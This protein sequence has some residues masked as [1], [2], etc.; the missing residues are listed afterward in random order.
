MN[1]WLLAPAALQAVVMLGDELHFHRRRGLP[2]WER[3]GHPLD[4]A[5]V[6]ACYGVAL[7]APPVSPFTVVYA[8]LVVVS[9]LLVTK[10]EFIHARRCSAAE[11]HLH[12]ILF[13][14]H[15][16]VLA[17]A[18]TLWM[19][20]SRRA[21]GALFALTLV[22]GVHQLVFWNVPWMRRFHAR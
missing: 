20:G 16:V 18:F 11:H 6:L 5:S 3:W 21:L 1:A 4:T 17:A 13:L 22:F 14:L 15:P 10:D 2:R 8:A 12:A 9:C 7:L 19:E